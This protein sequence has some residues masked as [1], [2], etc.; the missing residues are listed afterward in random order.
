MKFTRRDPNKG[1]IDNMMWLPKKFVNVE[2]VKR[3]LTF[4]FE[5]RASMRILSLWD[6]TDHHVVVPRGF[7]KPPDYPPVPFI[8]CRPLDFHPT[9]IKSRV[10][11]DHK[12]V[13]RRLLATGKNIQAESIQALLGAAGG[14]LQLACGK[15]KTVVALHLASL[16]QVP[17]I[18]HVDNTQ[19]MEQWLEAAEMFL[20]VP[21]GVGVVQ[22]QRRDW[23]HGLVLATYQTVASWA[24]TIPE[25]VRR[26]FGLIIW[27]EGHH[28]N[29]PVFSRGAPLFYGYRLALTATPTRS[30]GLHVVCHYH[31]GPILYKDVKQDMPP[32]IYFIW[33][34]LELDEEDPAVKLAV[35]DKND[36]IHL[37]KVAVYFGQ[38]RE[39]LEDVVLPQVEEAVQTGRKVLVLSNSVDEVINLQVLW[40]RGRGSKLYTDIPRPTN[41]ELGI[42]PLVEPVRLKPEQIKKTERGI[43]EIRANLRKNKKLDKAKREQFKEHIS[44]LQLKLTQHEAYRQINA[45]Y[46]RRQRQFVTDLLAEQGT[47]GVFTQMVDPQTRLDFLRNRQV[48]FAIMKY[49]KEGLDDKNLDTIIVSEPVSDRNTLQQIMGRPRD[50]KNAVLV[51]L[52]DDVKSMTGQCRELRKHLKHWPADEGGPFKYDMIG[53]PATYRRRGRSWQKGNL[54][55]P[56]L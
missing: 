49:G 14:T 32:K 36:E 4:E 5:D 18:V 38:W 52:E 11:L 42:D 19:L 25:E 43:K 27:D 28:V 1:Y 12:K 51:V 53:H 29:A 22:A 3:A 16:L 26:W 6:E 35:R 13:G 9:G 40:T 48:I 45:E 20:K 30:D 54:R 23:R 10:K 47:S 39:R 8:D 17:T 55:V 37:G 44:R 34:G 31:V 46:K 24:P 21:G 15:G 2:G 7:L 56:G 50:K 41:Q 33:T